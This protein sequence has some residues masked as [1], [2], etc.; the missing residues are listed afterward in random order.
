MHRIV[1][2]VERLV[3]SDTYENAPS[4]PAQLTFPRSTNQQPTPTNYFES[5]LD[6]TLHETDGAVRYPPIAPPGLGLSMPNPAA[7]SEAPLS[8][9]YTSRPTLPGIPSI[10]ST[11]LSPDMNESSAPRT[12][13]GLGQH[14]GEAIPANARSP[15]PGHASHDMT[16]N[17][18]I[19]RKS[20]AG[21]TSMHNLLGG[22]SSM[23]A[24]I[25]PSNPAAHHDLSG[26]SWD[27]SPLDRQ[28]SPPS[29]GVPSQPMSSGLANASWANDA[30]LAS[31]LS[32]GAGFPSSGPS[33]RRPASHF[34]AIGQTPSYGQGG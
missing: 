11:G 19:F 12:P 26:T 13:P 28:A 22:S 27:R 4:L 7:S 6:S 29:L 20:L 23:S 32:S 1:E 18:L 34:G 8:Q 2:G 24:W 10:W 33:S 9:S 25:S 16:P 3:E 15:V 31:T 17:E 5:S 30:F 14:P 21:Q